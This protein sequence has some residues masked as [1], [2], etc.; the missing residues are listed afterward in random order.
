M[1]HDNLLTSVWASEHC[2]VLNFVPLRVSGLLNRCMSQR[3]F[4]NN[5]K[6]AW[7]YLRCNRNFNFEKI[8]YDRK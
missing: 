4:K 2:L 3:N 8:Q 6:K 5:V 7:F 1:D